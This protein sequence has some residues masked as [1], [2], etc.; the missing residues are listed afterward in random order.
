MGIVFD[1]E[2]RAL[3]I[4]SSL[5]DSWDNLVMVVSN[6]MSTAN[7]LKFDDVVGL[8]V[9][10]EMRRKSSGGETSNAALTVENSGRQKERRKNQNNRD[11]SSSR[12]DK[13]RTKLSTLE[14]WNCCKKGHMKKD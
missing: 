5:P 10:E 6:S 13:S 9:S 2:V 4:L 7:T 12:R 1:D 8:L 11:R 3:L 14:C